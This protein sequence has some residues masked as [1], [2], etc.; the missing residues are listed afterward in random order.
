MMII[1]N[2]YIKKNGTI[3]QDLIKLMEYRCLKKDYSKHLFISV[4]ISL[5][6]TISRS[7]LIAQ[8]HQTFIIRI[9]FLMSKAC[10]AEGKAH[11]K[12]ISNF[13]L[14]FK[15]LII[16]ELKRR[17]FLFYFEPNFYIKISYEEI[18]FNKLFLTPKRSHQINNQ[19][20]PKRSLLI[21]KY[22]IFFLAPKR[23]HQI[24]NQIILPGY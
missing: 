13:F 6:L 5:S 19:L 10:T 7:A 16:S 12:K 17:K 22:L 24:N 4:L 11:Q 8:S 3:T 20:A 18:N 9:R 2:E 15:F 21:T 23:S 14:E 1:S